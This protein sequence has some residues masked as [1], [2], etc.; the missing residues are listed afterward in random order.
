M[1]PFR[2][3]FPDHRAEIERLRSSDLVF[4]EICRDYEMLSGLLPRDVNDSAWSDITESLS[5]IEAEIRAY[6]KIPVPET[7]NN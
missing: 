2:K 4:E 5:G 6:L 3:S 7:S 1:D